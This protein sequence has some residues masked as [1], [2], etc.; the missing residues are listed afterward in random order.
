MSKLT[1]ME[2]YK[3][4]TSKLFLV[5][6]LVTAVLSTA[7]SV[8]SPL[9]TK[10][11]TGQQMTSTLADVIASPFAVNLLMIFLFISAV[12]FLYMD[13]SGGYIKNIAG[14]TS[15]RG[16]IVLAKFTTIAVHN[17]VFFIV[18]AL[19]NVLGVALAGAL[20]VDGNIG[21]AI[22]TLLI[23]WLLS[24]AIS[25]ILMFFAV[26]LR[27]KTFAIIL[28]V[29]FPLGALSL[30][31]MGIDNL[32]ENVLK[33]G[34]NFSLADYMPDSLISS[35]N[36]IDNHLVVNAVVVAVIYIVLFYILTHFIFN[37]RDIK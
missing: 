28:G 17:L 6:L 16:G 31:Y 5:L 2:L 24:L 30:V 19:T 7:I 3:L 25:S 15:N 14:Q 1:K 12:S 34:G 18:A 35:V 10:M 27:S 21:G 29:I 37:K 22:L 20:T 8:G 33:I 9:V 32:L 23:K 13:F 36:V 11:L 4:R 26:G